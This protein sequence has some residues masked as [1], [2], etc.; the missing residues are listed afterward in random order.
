MLWFQLYGTLLIW[1]LLMMTIHHP[2]AAAK[3]NS[4]IIPGCRGCTSA[5]RCN[6]DFVDA[7][8]FL[9]DDN[10]DGNATTRALATAIASGAD[11]VSVPDIGRP[12]VVVPIS[13]VSFASPS[14][15]GGYLDHPMV[16]CLGQNFSH[17]TLRFELG[18]VVE[19]KR[20]A[21][22]G[23]GDSLLKS[24]GAN[25][26]TII[27]HGAT[28]RMHREDYR[29]ASLYAHS[30]Y[31]MGMSFYSVSGLHIEG[32]TV[33]RTGGDGLYLEN[34][35]DVNVT[36]CNFLNNYRQGM[37]IGACTDCSFTDTIFSNTSGTWPM[38]GVDIEPSGCNAAGVCNMK[39][40]VF[41]NCTADHNQ[42][43][44][45]TVSAGESLTIAFEDCTATGNGG[46]GS[47]VS[48]N[49]KP[50][51]NISDP[52]SRGL[53][54]WLNLTRCVA[55]GGNGPGLLMANKGL[56]VQLNVVDTGFDDTAQ[57]GPANGL[58]PHLNA[59]VLMATKI[60]SG[61]MM[62]SWGRVTLTN[63]TIRYGAQTSRYANA[64]PWL[65]V[66]AGFAT[67]I[68]G[69]RLKNS[70]E[71]LQVSDLSGSVTVSTTSQGSKRACIPEYSNFASAHYPASD[72]CRQQD[73]NTST[74]CKGHLPH[75]DIDL[76]VA[77]HAPLAPP[78]PSLTPPAPSPPRPPPAPPVPPVP[79]VN[80]SGL[81]ACVNS[82]GR[83]GC[84]RAAGGTIGIPWAE[85]SL[86]CSNAPPPPLPQPAPHSGRWECI[87]SGGYQKCWRAAGGTIGVPWAQ[88]KL[89]CSNRL[90]AVKNDDTVALDAVYV[91][92]ARGDDVADG[93]S[94]SP[95]R[96]IEAAQKQIRS[97]EVSTI[98]LRGGLHVVPAGGLY[99]TAADSGSAARPVRI[100]AYAGE[101]PRLSGGV[102]LPPEAFKPVSSDDPVFARLG[103][104][105]KT[106]RANLSAYG[107]TDMG[108]VVDPAPVGTCS[109]GRL[110]YQRMEV[111]VGDQP[112]T[113]ARWPNLQDYTTKGPGGSAASW[114]RT[115]AGSHGLDIALR[116]DAPIKNWRVPR[117]TCEYSPRANIC[118]GYGLVG[119]CSAQRGDG[120]YNVSCES[121][122]DCSE[123]C[124]WCQCAGSAATCKYGVCQ[125]G[126][127]SGAGHG[128]SG[129]VIC[130]NTTPSKP[131]AATPEELYL[132]GY[133][134][135]DWSDAFLQVESVNA[136]AQQLKLKTLPPYTSG[137]VAGYRFYVLNSPTD[138]DVSGE[139]WV[140]TP[141]KMLYMI[142]PT[143]HGQASLSV[144]VSNSAA[145]VLNFENTSFISIEGVLV[146]GSRSR[147]IH[148]VGGRNISITDATV[149]NIGGIG[150]HLE[151][152]W[153][154]T[155]SGCTI[156]QTGDAG[157]AI[158]RA[159]TTVGVDAD[160]GQA[161][162]LTPG[163]NSLTD[164]TI[165]FFGR[166]C[167]S[168]R[169]GVSSA[170]MGVRITGNEI[171]YGP[172][173]GI[174]PAGN[175]NQIMR[176]ALHHLVMQSS[177]MGAIDAR[178]QWINRGHVIKEN[179]FYSIGNHEKDACN[180][181]SLFG[182]DGIKAVRALIRY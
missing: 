109:S 71:I 100:T 110:F 66:G 14:C 76:A 174:L 126:V 171:S 140:D 59:P 150:I 70:T 83:A 148:V 90:S 152:S 158:N 155:I 25:N 82:R 31:R 96:T 181:A 48:Q 33:E 73:S 116:P 141:R 142:P 3:A 54:G 175:D 1:A 161:L 78:S 36:G 7:S 117:A 50:R 77:C 6:A 124:G 104:P 21:F 178:G 164:S 53:V 24:Y 139:F 75:S 44:G 173:A 10:D 180:S 170:G 47:F 135:Y 136:S 9:L 32:L 132:H 172:H 16:F 57:D 179:L 88:C 68:H 60:Q 125:T 95:L 41:R 51:L 4:A 30:E 72:S 122:T 56:G 23:L 143:Q 39:N 160:A 12:W 26:I 130:N 8:C 156:T 133:F 118:C 103:D 40:I 81:W 121:E 34:D 138:L 74:W 11:V 94:G 105:G 29:N 58:P 162:S 86:N 107:V 102:D 65:L 52:S 27:G 5:A 169:P 15:H 87:Q 89:N 167:H 63:L 55:R 67:T 61:H 119:G 147:G 62:Y 154:T 101:V 46:S 92:A 45:F 99:F 120:W 127:P 69:T 43:G 114:T 98:V 165:S 108:L 42:G 145:A 93:S 176:N 80:H 13:G 153:N 151:R 137:M 146:E 17:R 35:Y 144:M 49:F 97:G 157:V 166:I 113:L 84:W 37:S 28:L 20:G 112:M 85:C 168:F 18:A 163:G 131:T 79:A 111:F 177:D 22:H 123:L 2:C 38:C 134:G 149:R 91:D 182:C 115:D 19:A 128:L 64:M 159:S 129:G 106:L